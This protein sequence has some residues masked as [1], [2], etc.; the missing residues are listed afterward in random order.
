VN[1]RPFN[2]SSLTVAAAMLC[3][4]TASA[5][6]PPNPPVAAGAS[7]TS[8]PEKLAPETNP[9]VRAA[10]DMPR[11][12]PKHYVSAVLALVDLGRPELAVPILKELQGLNLSDEQR[13]A[14]VNEF[15]SRRMLQ[16]SKTAALAPDGGQFA[17]ACMTAA[18]AQARDPQ[19]IARLVGELSDTSDVVRHAATVDL[20]TAGQLGVNATLEALA[21]E[22][23]PQRKYSIAVAITSMDR[24]A[25]EPLMAMLATNDPALEAEVVRL[26]TTLQVAQALPLVE[27]AQSAPTSA[28]A[29]RAEQ[30]LLDALR[31]YQKYVP[32]FASDENEQSDLWQWNDATKR[33]SSVKLPADEVQTVW[34]AR[35]ALALAQLRPENTAY[36]RQAIVLGLESA[37]L[38]T[39]ASPEQPPQPAASAQ[40][41][42]TADT[43]MLNNV[44]SD[45]L[46][47]N[48][49]NAAVAAA[50]LL[51]DRGD[52]GVL[53]AV[54]PQ[55]APLVDGLDF[56]NLRVQF[57]ALSTILKL[58]PKSPFPGASRVPET[59]GHFATGANQRRAVVA[60]PGVDR[61]STLAGELTKLG[62]DT[63]PAMRGAAAVRQALQSAD[64][65]LVLVDVDIDGP[66]IRDV[67][68]ALRSSPATG[69]VPIGI[70]ATSER[71]ET[72]KQIADDHSR[73][74]AFVRPQ[75][76]EAITPIVERLSQLSARNH[77][78]PKD[79]AAMATQAMG[80]LADL[81]SRESTFY[82]LKRQ[83]P[84]IQAA[85]YQ[86]ELAEHA[87]SAL[88][89]LGT[90][91]SQK[92]LVDFA[93]QASV[94]IGARQQAAA[95]F[96]RSV[97]RSGILLTEEEILR[98]YDRYNA[99]A[100]ADAG[101]QQVL[102]S[103]LDSLE[104][105][106]GKTSERRN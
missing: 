94:N 82:D 105:V 46:K 11:T 15:G 16:L 23:D 92:S 52:V 13:A 60:M 99:S 50:K 59:L 104:S 18:A 30:M 83:A 79:R 106:R 64:L 45:S 19:R 100:T 78:S 67:L 87:I 55:A 27:A 84:I 68:F 26:L 37:A 39:A 22:R 2:L 98:Q 96:Q 10:V 63:E 38:L 21:T 33:L 72:A 7:A 70:L 86:P 54:T 61:A 51:A 47:G 88:S 9:A 97:T 41:I 14:L 81:L 65:E 20:A 28:S 58:N 24:L 4:V 85:L 29:G 71:L 75:T 42:A 36:Q 57:A 17:D 89:R 69:Q 102:V 103:L 32:T 56:P 73:V 91:E 49:I 90:P 40:L 74:I 66:G 12:E 48:Y 31:L 6:Q 95:A 53:Y 44:L 80:W 8:T 76:D 25:V 5:Q 43:T 34:A 77:L 35:L 101:T 62:I 3:T 1:W 93:S